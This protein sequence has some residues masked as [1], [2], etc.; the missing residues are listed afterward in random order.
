[1]C[2]KFPS[3]QIADAAT[4]TKL[5]F[6]RLTAAAATIDPDAMRAAAA[7]VAETV[8]AG[9]WIY[10]CGNGG[11][12]AIANHL[13][14]DFSKGIRT[15]TPLQ[16]R[17]NSLSAHL[18]TLTA[19]ANDISYDDVFVYQLSG[20]GKPGDLLIAISSSGNSENIVRPI[21]WAR[22]NGVRTIALTGFEGGRVAPI[23]DVSLHVNSN[24]YGVVEDVHQSLMHILAQ[25]TRQGHMTNEQIVCTKF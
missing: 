16:P 2:T 3:E 13:H 10:S 17:I 8:K 22:E 11:S 12:A 19:I 24:N 5:Y 1:M 21:A 14:C 25:F 23:A 4:Y 18:E 6:E 20:V 7:L 9:N 15:N